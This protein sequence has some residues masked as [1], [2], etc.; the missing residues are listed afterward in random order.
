[1][2]NII[3]PH[4]RVAKTR[5][6]RV[7]GVISTQNASLENLLRAQIAAEIRHLS[8]R[9][10][11]ISARGESRAHS[12]VRCNH[13]IAVALGAVRFRKFFTAAAMR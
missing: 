2:D 5:R 1:M 13:A 4:Q 8:R 6:R 3:G 11:P 12:F 10:V 9:A 7:K